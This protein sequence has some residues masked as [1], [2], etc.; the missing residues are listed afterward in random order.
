MRTNHVRGAGG[1]ANGLCVC[2]LTIDSRQLID[3]CATEMHGNNDNIVLLQ[4]RYVCTLSYLKNLIRPILIRYVPRHYIIIICLAS[5]RVI[6]ILR[7]RLHINFRPL[8]PATKCTPVWY[9]VV[10]THPPNEYLYPNLYSNF[11]NETVNSI[12][13]SSGVCRF[14]SLLNH[15]CT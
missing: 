12:I 4:N 14:R 11:K 6:N 5:E 10:S 15:H 3:Y 13:R 1:F 9:K 8:F 2:G 7:N